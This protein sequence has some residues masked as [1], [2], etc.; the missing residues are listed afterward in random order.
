MEDYEE[1]G[2]YQFL[3]FHRYPPKASTF[4][5]AVS[6]RKVAARYLGGEI[7]PNRGAIDVSIGLWPELLTMGVGLQRKAQP[8]SF[9]RHT[10]LRDYT[11]RYK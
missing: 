1:I 8:V 4:V 3:I 11:A 7:R 6:D 5:A 10:V 9:A 2:L